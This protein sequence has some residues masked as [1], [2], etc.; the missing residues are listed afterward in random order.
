MKSYIRKIRMETRVALCVGLAMIV[1]LVAT[2]NPLDWMDCTLILC[3]FV[4]GAE[5]TGVA[6]DLV[7]RGIHDFRVHHSRTNL[8]VVSDDTAIKAA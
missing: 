2:H 7:T 4:G 5:L 1:F 3:I 6:Y 8:K